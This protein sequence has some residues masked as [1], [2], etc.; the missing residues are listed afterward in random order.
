MRRSASLSL[1]L[2][3]I[4]V[5]VGFSATTALAQAE[6]AAERIPT[7]IYFMVLGNL[8]LVSIT[9]ILLSIVAV[10]LIIQAFIRVR[11]PVL[12]PDQST[13][14]VREM[15]GNRQFKELIEYSETDPSFVSKAINPALKRA[16]SF[17]A[18]REAME[19]AVAEQTAEEFRKL[20]YLNVLANVGP[21]LGLLGTVIGIMK[22]FLDMRVAE[23][24]TGTGANPAVLAEGISIALGT[25]MLGLML[26]IPC[27]V[28]YGVLRTKVDRLTTEGALQAEELL[29]MIK[30]AEAK[31]AAAAAARPVVKPQPG[32]APR[33]PAPAAPAPV[34]APQ[35]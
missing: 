3:L 34:A 5:V 2:A 28:A 14:T 4:A 10:T 19:T 22:A 6:P 29:L 15:I 32:A 1:R 33:K 20:E 7:N 17:N 31:P 9:I 12:L 8:E 35:A 21:L 23:A 13:E 30:P 18:M 16:P 24:T 26:A 27:L 11:R 25:T